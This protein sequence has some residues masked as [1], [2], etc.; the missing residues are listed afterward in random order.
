V[1]RGVSVVATVLRIIGVLI[2]AVLVIHILLTVFD[3]NPANAFATWIKGTADT[4]SLGLTN[5]FL[6]K[7]P[8]VAVGVNYGIAA[9]VWLFITQIVVALV[10][11]VG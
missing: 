5:L 8:K 1:R 2:V 3:A 7:D 9:L 10:R 4:F 6:P 11:R